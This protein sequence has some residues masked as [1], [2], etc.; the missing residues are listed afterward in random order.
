MMISLRIVSSKQADHFSRIDQLGLWYQWKNKGNITKTKDVSFP[1]DEFCFPS[2]TKS[3]IYIK[4][5]FLQ[6]NI[7]NKQFAYD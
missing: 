4:N 7:F 1:D 2:H 5:S 3:N 6:D